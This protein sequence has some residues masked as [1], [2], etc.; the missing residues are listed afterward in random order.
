[1]APLLSQRIKSSDSEERDIDELIDEEDEEA[2]FSIVNRLE[3]PQAITYTTHDLHLLIHHGE[4][5]LNP[6]YQ[7]GRSATLESRH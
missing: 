3:A 7:R 1:M 5:D 4:I 6:P 2:E